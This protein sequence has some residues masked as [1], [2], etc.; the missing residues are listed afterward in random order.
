MY[1]L[2]LHVGHTTISS[3]H[4]QSLGTEITLTFDRGP[5][6]NECVENNLRNP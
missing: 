2:R 1:A 6:L 4:P 3:Q 5:Q